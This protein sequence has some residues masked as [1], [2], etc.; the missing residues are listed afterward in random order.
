[1][2]YEEKIKEII[3]EHPH[4]VNSQFTMT[5]AEAEKLFKKGFPS[6]K[7]IV[8]GAKAKSDFG[9][10]AWKPFYDALKKKESE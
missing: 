6:A 4:L 3:R 2:T 7:E 1:M 8:D 10:E 9:E 5:R